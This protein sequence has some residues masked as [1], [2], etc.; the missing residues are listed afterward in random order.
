MCAC[1]QEEEG[2]VDEWLRQ[3]ELRGE[4]EGEVKDK[5]RLVSDFF[6]LFY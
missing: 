6:S 4:G 1:G 5:W 3:S 2:S